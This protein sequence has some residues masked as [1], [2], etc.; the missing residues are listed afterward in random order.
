MCSE[1]ITF[2]P[3]CL[4]INFHADR[5]VNSSYYPEFATTSA[6]TFRYIVNYKSN[7]TDAHGIITMDVEA[8]RCTQAHC[9]NS[10]SLRGFCGF[11]S[12]CSYGRL[13][14]RMLHEGFSLAL[15]AFL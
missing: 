13:S 3:Q 14:L 5:Y 1:P 7:D 15:L 6:S 4:A 8:K 12:G 11:E 10:V 9:R 2:Q